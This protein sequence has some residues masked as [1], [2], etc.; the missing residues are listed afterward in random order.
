[1]PR[2]RRPP[3]PHAGR[4]SG[5]SRLRH[6]SDGRDAARVGDS[7][8]S[9]RVEVVPEQNAPRSPRPAR[10]G[11][12]GRS[13]RG[14]RR[15]SSR[16]RAHTARARA[17]RRPPWPH[18]RGRAAERR[19]TGRLPPPASDAIASNVSIPAISRFRRAAVDFRRVDEPGNV[20]FFLYFDTQQRRGR[21]GAARCGRLRR[22]EHR[23]GD[24]TRRGSRLRRSTPPVC[25]RPATSTQR[26]PASGRSPPPRTVRSTRSRCRG[27]GTRQRSPRAARRADDDTR[28]GDG[29]DSRRRFSQGSAANAAPRCLRLLDLRLSRERATGTGTRTGSARGRRRSR[30]GGGRARRSAGSR[31]ARGG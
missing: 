10:T 3:P 11:E 13:G 2:R 8:E 24:T 22:R 27:R 16:A 28:I 31:V 12:A 15:R 5:R 23:P 21:A 7:D 4:R 18:D 1:M 14:R 29:G 19:P 17:S 30:A 6:R 26:S 20:T 25:S 9:V